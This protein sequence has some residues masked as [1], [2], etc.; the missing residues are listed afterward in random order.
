[1]KVG[2]KDKGNTNDSFGALLGEKDS[3]TEK[4]EKEL[5]SGKKVAFESELNSPV[6]S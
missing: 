3:A 4:K 1:M 6:K 5:N 2:G